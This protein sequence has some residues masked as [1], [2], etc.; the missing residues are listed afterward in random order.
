VVVDL[1]H[2]DGVPDYLITREFF[3]DLKS[4]VA[5]R[6]IVVFN[7]FADLTHPRAYA[8]FLTTLRTEFP[9]LVLYRTSDI[10]ATH[11]NSYVVA[12]AHPLA[13]PL[14]VPLDDVPPNVAPMLAEILANP[15]PIDRELL[16]YGVV[17]TDAY[18]PVV[19]DL[20]AVQLTYRESIVENLPAAF[21]LN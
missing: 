20:A 3:H 19:Q 18:N 7:T 1:F 5:A 21:F 10:G 11:V 9:S 6:G 12:A 4:C 2:G 16:Q 14:P 13:E 17:I 15:R 8:H